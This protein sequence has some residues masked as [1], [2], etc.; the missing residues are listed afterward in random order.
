MWWFQCCSSPADC[1]YHNL[2]FISSS[3]H[4]LFFF[5][6]QPLLW[7]WFMTSVNSSF[8]HAQLSFHAGWCG[9]CVWVAPLMRDQS[10]E[11][12]TLRGGAGRGALNLCASCK[13]PL[14]Q[15]PL[16]C[17][18]NTC[19][20]ALVTGYWNLPQKRKKWQSAEDKKKS[21]WNSLVSVY[22]CMQ[23]SVSLLKTLRH[24][25][26]CQWQSAQLA[27]YIRYS[28]SCVGQLTWWGKPCIVR[29][30]TWTAQ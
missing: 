24:W 3:P 14:L 8:N 15:L 19:K 23:K 21:F 27:L 18:K 29:N 26:L 13:L 22:E 4:S 20:A 17:Y 16:W 6:H 28:I 2:Y 11:A 1:C 7:Y 30:S 25:H 5:S 10:A 9:L 12:L